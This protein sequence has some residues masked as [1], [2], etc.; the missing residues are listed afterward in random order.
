MKDRTPSNPPIPGQARK[1]RRAGDRLVAVEIERV[2]QACATMN[3]TLDRICER[4][5][6]DI[7]AKQAALTNM[8]ECNRLAGDAPLAI[9]GPGGEYT[10]EVRP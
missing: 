2:H 8:R 7:A 5:E 1:E 6:R 4:I 3:A 10:R 9:L